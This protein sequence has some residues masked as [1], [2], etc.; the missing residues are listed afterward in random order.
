MVQLT[1]AKWEGEIIPD[2]VVGEVDIAPRPVAAV[3]EKWR[4]DNHYVA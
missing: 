2:T 4:E 1:T 3:G